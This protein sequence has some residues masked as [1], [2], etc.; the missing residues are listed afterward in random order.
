MRFINWMLLLAALLFSVGCS[1]A[2]PTAPENGNQVTEMKEIREF[3]YQHRGSSAYDGYRYTFYRDETGVHLTAD[4]N[5]GREKLQV[6]LDVETMEKLEQIVFAHQMQNWDGFSKTNS[7]VMDG[8]GFSLHITFMDDTE[9]SAKGNNA[10]PAGYG[11]AENAFGGMFREMV[12]VH[13]AEITA[14]DP[15]DFSS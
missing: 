15:A 12:K 13:E 3:S 11:D 7:H 4:M 6:T 10:F 1:T 8:E 5:S 9:I 14:A 2:S